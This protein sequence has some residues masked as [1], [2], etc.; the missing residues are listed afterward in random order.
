[1]KRLIDAVS[2]DVSRAFESV[3]QVST[4]NPGREDG[5]V[6]YLPLDVDTDILFPLP[7]LCPR[8]LPPPSPL[9]SHSNPTRRPGS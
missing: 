7:Y 5:L 2:P 1:V 9:L 6:R 4:S 8:P 3:A